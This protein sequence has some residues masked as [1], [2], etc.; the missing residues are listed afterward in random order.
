MRTSCAPSHNAKRTFAAKP[1]A[2][3]THSDQPGIVFEPAAVSTARRARIARGVVSGGELGATNAS[4]V[5]S[6]L[7]AMSNS[8]EG[9][10]VT[11]LPP[12]KNANPVPNLPGAPGM[13]PATVPGCPAKPG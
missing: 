2:F 1:R 4:I 9:A 13:A 6:A 8:G 3:T 5:A 7:A 10:T 12:A 11:A